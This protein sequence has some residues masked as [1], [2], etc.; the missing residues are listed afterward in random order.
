MGVPSEKHPS[1]QRLECWMDDLPDAVRD[2]PLCRLSIPGSHD[3]FTYSLEKSGTAG[4][5]QPPFIRTLT[6]LF[7]KISR[8][9]LYRWSVTQK[10]SFTE[11]L[12][13]GIRYFDIRLEAVTRNGE[14][15]FRIL[16]CLLGTRIVDLL[17]ELKKFL[18]ETKSEVIILDFQHLYMFEHHDHQELINFIMQEFQGLLCSYQQ[19]VNKINLSNLKNSGVRLIV[20]YPAIYHCKNSQLRNTGLDPA[21]LPF[22]WPRSFFPTPWPDTANANKLRPFLDTKL[23]DRNPGVF[24]ISQGVLTPNIGTIVLHPFSTLD[25]TC[26]EKANKTVEQWLED[27]DRSNRRPNIVITDFVAANSRSTSLIES[28]VRINYDS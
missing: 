4:P 12:K 2:A 28:I 20:I 14:R 9:I 23:K 25:K 15:E 24:F 1:Q 3:S 22:L 10:R 19:E 21:I 6:K 17:Q 16:H 8:W 11:Q 13:S 18:D 27:L 26:G 5:D 7:P